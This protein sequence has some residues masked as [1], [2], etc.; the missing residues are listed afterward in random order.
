M[1]DQEA[2]VDAQR[3]QIIDTIAVLLARILQTE[4]TITGDT[5]L[6]DEIGLSSS[7]V[8]QLLLDLEDELEIQ[9]DVE[10]MDEDETETVGDLGDYI[11]A[12]SVPL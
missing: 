3:Q 5:R 4:M 9:I 2:P 6:M 11:V 7:L 8:L 1:L 12:H 10:E